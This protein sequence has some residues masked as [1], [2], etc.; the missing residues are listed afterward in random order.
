MTIEQLDETRL[1]IS[2]CN[3]DMQVFSLEYESMGF[4]DPHSRRVL[5]RLLSLAGSRTGISVSDKSLMVEAMPHNEGCILLVT[6]LPKSEQKRRTYK[7]KKP[8]D[9]FICAFDNVESFLSCT[10]QLY[11]AGFLFRGSKAYLLEGVY[12]LILTTGGYLP[13][14]AQGL[15]NEYASYCMSGRLEAAKIT[16]YGSPIA[17]SHAIMQIG[18]AMAG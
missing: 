15:L 12:Y 1:I 2:L 6:L 9:C 18:S 8:C 5:K 17:P 11:Q 10:Q 13:F 16:E 7:I 3:E 4:D 14:K